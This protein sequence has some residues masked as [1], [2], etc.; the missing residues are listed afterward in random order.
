MIVFYLSCTLLHD[1]HSTTIDFEDFLE[2]LLLSSQSLCQ[3]SFVKPGP[4]HHALASQ[5]SKLFASFILETATAQVCEKTIPL[6][7]FA[8]FGEKN[9]LT[10]SPTYFQENKKH[11]SFFLCVITCFSSDFLF[12]SNTFFYFPYPFQC[13]NCPLSLFSIYFSSLVSAFLSSEKCFSPFISSIDFNNIYLDTTTSNEADF[14][15][16]NCYR[17]NLSMKRKKPNLFFHETLKAEF[18][19]S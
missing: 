9:S 17:N 15:R 13:Q 8:F 2:V 18:V 3:P 11:P 7:L 4:S 12:L 5:V 6:S 14:V 16:E 1:S 19:F 10:N